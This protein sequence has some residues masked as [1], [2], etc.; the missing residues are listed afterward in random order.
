MAFDAVHVEGIRRV[1]ALDIGFAKEL[2]YRI[3]LLGIARASEAGIE[4]RVHPCMVPEDAPIARV[5][6]VFN[7]VVAEGDFVGRVMLEGRGAGAGPTASAVVADLVD[8]ARG[9]TTPV[10][11]ASP[12][13][14]SDAPSVPMTAHVG[15][16]YLRL[17]VVD[18]PGVIADVTAVLRDQGVSLESMLQRGR[19]PGEA[20]PVVLVTHETA[21][22]AMRAA[23]KRIGRLD[24]VMEEPAVVRIE[25][26]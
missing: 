24:A 4:A 20:V 17:M 9:R 7:A 2:G 6:G 13:A 15:C 23:L 22:S 19:A 25:G 26:G 3:K 11:G 8:I 10:W 14:L 18:R 5:D 21:E 1:S 16:Y 12:E